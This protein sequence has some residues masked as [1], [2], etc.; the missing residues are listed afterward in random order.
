MF[1]QGASNKYPQHVFLRK[2]SQNYHQIVLLNKSLEEYRSSLR[3]I[4]NYC[5]HRQYYALCSH[6]VQLK[7]FAFGF[8]YRIQLLIFCVIVSI[9]LYR[10]TWCIFFYILYIYTYMHVTLYAGISIRFASNICSLG[11]VFN[12]LYTT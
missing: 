4:F 6:R 11:F 10:M 9:I 2:S 1:R 7:I 12:I 3:G 5:C 8:K